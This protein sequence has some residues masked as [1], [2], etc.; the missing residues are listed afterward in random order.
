[1]KSEVEKREDASIELTAS[2]LASRDKIFN[3]NAPYHSSPSPGT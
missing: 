1:M 3:D 2:K